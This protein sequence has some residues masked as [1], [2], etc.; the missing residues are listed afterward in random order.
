MTLEEAALI[1]TLKNEN[2]GLSIAYFELS[3]RYRALELKHQKLKDQ[4]N[5]C[6]HKAQ[7]LFN[8][9]DKLKHTNKRDMERN[10]KN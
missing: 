1:E 9:L 5:E 6:R 8:L 2:D 4:V 7:Y 3:K 10:S